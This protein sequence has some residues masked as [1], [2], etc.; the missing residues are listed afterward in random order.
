MAGTAEPSINKTF[1]SRI[2]LKHDISTN[3]EKATNFKPLQGELIIYDDLNKIKIGNGGDYINDLPFAS[4]DVYN[5]AE[6][7]TL[8]NEVLV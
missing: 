4:G 5:E 6:I 7:E 2:I 8:Y 3:W 1:K